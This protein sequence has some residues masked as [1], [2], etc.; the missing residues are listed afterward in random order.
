M[1]IVIIC[2]V[3]IFLPVSQPTHNLP[4]AS[5][6]ELGSLCFAK[7]LVN[8][9]LPVVLQHMA[10]FKKMSHFVRFG[11][12]K[13]FQLPPP[14][15][16]TSTTGLCSTTELSNVRRRNVPGRNARC[17]KERRTNGRGNARCVVRGQ[18]PTTR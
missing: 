1:H 6:I 15:H 16:S 2:A 17:P 9:I 13:N 11:I 7:N 8:F 10:F 12:K 4:F 3:V 18:K 5:A 14:S